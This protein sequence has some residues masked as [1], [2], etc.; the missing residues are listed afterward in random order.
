[1]NKN[2]RILNRLKLAETINNDDVKDFLFNVD[3]VMHTCHNPIVEVFE[4]WKSSL[5]EI[6]DSQEC[7]EIFEK[8]QF[9]VNNLYEIQALV[10]TAKKKYN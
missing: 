6:S 3:E 8:I 1:M 10:E 7:V 9:A 5:D 2:N 4:G